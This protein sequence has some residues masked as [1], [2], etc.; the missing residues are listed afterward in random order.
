MKKYVEKENLS[1]IHFLGFRRDVLKFLQISNVVALLSYLEGLSK[2]IMEAIVNNI[3]C[4]VTIKGLIKSNENG[5]V[6]K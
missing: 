1:G 3:S 2:S 6:V 5:F 4:V